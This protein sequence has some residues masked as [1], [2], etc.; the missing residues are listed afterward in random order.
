MAHGVHYIFCLD[1]LV[2]CFCVSAL[3][4]V[5]APA[6][7]AH[8]MPDKQPVLCHVPLLICTSHPPLDSH[9]DEWRS[10]T[11]FTRYNR[12]YNWF[13]K[14]VERT[15][16]ACSTS[17]QTGFYNQLDSQSYTWYSRL[18][19][20]FDNRLNVCIHDTTGCQTG[21]KTVVLCI[22]TFNRLSGWFDN[23]LHRVNG[24]L[25]HIVTT[26]SCEVSLEWLLRCEWLLPLLLLLLSLFWRWLQWQA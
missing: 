14:R 13:D 23:R 1:G 17:C 3:D 12:L 20:G 15:A 16:T 19:N 26:E 2:P 4:H 22:Q 21:L 25:G 11:L 5:P 24:A 8:G 18:S 7:S 6:T 10:N 9:Q